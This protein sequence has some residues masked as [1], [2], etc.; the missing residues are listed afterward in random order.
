MSSCRLRARLEQYGRF[1]VP[2]A[3]DADAHCAVYHL[4]AVFFHRV[5]YCRVEGDY[6]NPH[7]EGVFGDSGRGVPLMI[8]LM[9]KSAHAAMQIS[10]MHVCLFVV[11]DY[12]TKR[13]L[14]AIED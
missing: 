12:Y 5:G 8:L 1:D 14:S 3:V 4:C 10:P 11:A 7:D 2:G 13:D 9:G 6:S